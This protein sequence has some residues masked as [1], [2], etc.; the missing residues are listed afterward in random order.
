MFFINEITK[1]DYQS[2]KI[3]FKEYLTF[4]NSE[5][6]DSII[7]SSWDKIINKDEQ[8]YCFGCYKSSEKN[9]ELIGIMNFIF[10]KSTWSKNQVC[11][12]EDLFIKE[13]YRL[14]GCASLLLKNLV[15]I[16]KIKNVEKIY[17][18]TKS[19]NYQAQSLYDKFAI[20]TD[21]LEYEILL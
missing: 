6:T 9:K 17:W 18:K 13:D 3:I 19:D 2:W 16:C 5:L 12:L 20:Q 11:Y 14:K 10:H 7:K 21:F 8:I 4:Y 15:K 1:N